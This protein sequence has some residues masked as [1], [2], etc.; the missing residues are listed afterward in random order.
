MLP[1]TAAFP[2]EQED[3]MMLVALHSGTTP[4]LHPAHIRVQHMLEYAVV[5]DPLRHRAKL[6]E[7]ARMVFDRQTNEGM[8][9]PKDARSELIVKFN[10]AKSALRERA[11]RRFATLH[12]EINAAIRCIEA[13]N[14]EDAKTGEM[15]DEPEAEQVPRPQ[16]AM[17]G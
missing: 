3:L 8:K 2:T 15:P 5:H 17:L 11:P 13:Q 16:P 12:A 1:H 7:A 14:S 4:D 10:G 9:V 6:L